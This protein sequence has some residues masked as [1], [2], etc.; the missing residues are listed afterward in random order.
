MEE[1][2]GVRYGD[3]SV[4]RCHGALRIVTFSRRRRSKRRCWTRFDARSW[5]LRQVLNRDFR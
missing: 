3:Y 1:T 4:R 2:A 5:C